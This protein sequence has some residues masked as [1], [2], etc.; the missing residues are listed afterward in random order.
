MYSLFVIAAS[1]VLY[2]RGSFRPN[3]PGNGPRAIRAVSDAL[4]P[5]RRYAHHLYL[6]NP[7][8]CSGCQCSSLPRRSGV[9][10]DAVALYSRIHQM[11]TSG[12]PPRFQCN[13]QIGNKAVFEILVNN[14]SPPVSSH[15][16]NRGNCQP[17]L[18]IHIMGGHAACP[19]QEGRDETRCSRGGAGGAERDRERHFLTRQGGEW[20]GQPPEL[21]VLMVSDSRARASDCGCGISSDLPCFSEGM[22]F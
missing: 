7:P 6:G 13:L 3:Q 21:G 5:P 15:G 1:L 17:N 9:G 20:C 10:R 11:R 12:P 8:P 22:F 2:N 14:C 4:L 19:R 18:H 16:G